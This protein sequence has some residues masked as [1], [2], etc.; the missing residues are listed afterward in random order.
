[1]HALRIC[2]SGVGVESHHPAWNKGLQHTARGRQ[3]GGRGTRDNGI[4]SRSE[5]MSNAWFLTDLVFAD[6]ALSGTGGGVWPGDGL[7]GQWNPSEK[8]I[9]AGQRVFRVL[10]VIRWAWGSKIGGFVCF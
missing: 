2:I 6:M 10:K 8:F 5:R 7:K 9:G 3:R 1:M 4:C